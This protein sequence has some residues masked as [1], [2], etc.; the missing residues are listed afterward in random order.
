MVGA[1]DISAAAGRAMTAGEEAELWERARRARVLVTIVARS[2]GGFSAVIAGLG[3]RGMASADDPYRAG[4]AA[5][6]LVPGE[7]AA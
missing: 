7:A 3:R 1:V 2:A 6:A 4:L 5:L